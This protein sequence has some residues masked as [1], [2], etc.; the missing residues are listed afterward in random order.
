[1]S[2]TPDQ[3]VKADSPAPATPA[4]PPGQPGAPPPVGTRPLRAAPAPASVVPAPDTAAVPALSD[5]V[6]GGDT[7]LRDLVAFG[8]AV[9]AGRPVSADAVETYRRRADADLQ[10]HAFRILHNRVETIRREAMEE[11]LAR[12]P[13]GQT[14]SLAVVA[15]LVAIALA[16][17]ALLLAWLAA[18][19]LFA[20]L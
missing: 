18:P 4:P 15:N 10:A 9:E 2:N 8:M 1:M 17:V 6:S 16:G 14:F 19:Q 3:A 13:R 20:G 7:H 5:F 11:Q 12:M